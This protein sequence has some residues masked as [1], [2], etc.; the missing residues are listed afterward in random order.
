MSLINGL[1]AVVSALSKIL[2]VLGCVM[3]VGMTALACANMFMRGAMNDPIQGTY[4]MMG[5]CGA[6]VCAF[7]LAPTQVRK[8]HIALTMLQGKFPP[9]V[10]RGFDALSH[11]CC[12]VFFGLCAWRTTKYAMD[13]IEF[14]ELSQDL[15]I[16]FHPFVLCVAFGVGVLTLA[17][18]SDFLKAVTGRQTS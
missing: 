4:E 1:D 16:P 3:L 8:G 9:M 15:L 13:L 2:L 10:E 17:L 7:A 5:F 14:G 12:T 11:L 6:L 18:L